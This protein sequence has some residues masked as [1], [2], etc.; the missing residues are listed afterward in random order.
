MKKKILLILAN[1]FFPLASLESGYDLELTRFHYQHSFFEVQKNTVSLNQQCLRF[2][3]IQ[4]ISSP[5]YSQGC[6]WNT[7]IWR[8][9]S[10]IVY[11]PGQ[12]MMTFL[13]RHSSCSHSFQFTEE[14]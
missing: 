1:I 11:S 4:N 10:L 13:S 6:M 8:T 12:A 3:K 2:D 7:T 14:N 9:Y 5:L